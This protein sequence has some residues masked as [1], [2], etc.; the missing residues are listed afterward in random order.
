[1]RWLA[2]GAALA[3]WAAP[4]VAWACTCAVTEL[5]TLPE[6]GVEDVPRNAVVAVLGVEPT[7][8]VRL[9]DREGDVTLTPTLLFTD[10]TTVSNR[11]DHAPLAPLTQ[12]HLFINGAEVASFVTGT[13]LDE[14]PPPAPGLGDLR[15]LT[16]D[17]GNSSCGPR[18]GDVRFTLV[19]RDEV[20]LYHVELA[21]EDSSYAYTV[22]PAEL[23]LLGDGACGLAAGLD[24]GEEVCL[25]LTA[26]DGAGN[27]SPTDE[28]C[29]TVIEC[30]PVED[31]AP[32]SCDT[33]PTD[34]SGG[35]CGCDLGGRQR[36]A[37]PVALLAFLGLVLLRR[38]SSQ[39]RG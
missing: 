14:T 11:Y 4:A 21:G 29:T 18:R 3:V 12:Y 27:A 23:V 8:T 9:S 16:A 30:P 32:L 19:P 2:A 7:A 6:N 17:A 38:R 31:G 25:R 26:L 10:G 1:M 5:G 37:G 34:G 13:D 20:V 36:A 39:R 24:P 15:L 33:A 28:L 35:G 22:P